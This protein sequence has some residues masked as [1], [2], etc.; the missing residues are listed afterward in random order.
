MVLVSA[1]PT[2]RRA[3]DALC[4]CGLWGGKPTAATECVHWG[5]SRQHWTTYVD[6]LPQTPEPPWRGF[7][8]SGLEGTSLRLGG[9]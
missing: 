1:S 9:L 5:G 7:R 4:S 2:V 6:Y 8:P 3:A